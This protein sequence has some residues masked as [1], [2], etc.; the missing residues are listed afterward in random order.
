MIPI[1]GMKVGQYYTVFNYKPTRPQKNLK[2]QDRTIVAGIGKKLSPKCI[3]PGHRTEKVRKNYP[4]DALIIDNLETLFAKTVDKS[5]SNES[6]SVVERFTKPRAS[7]MFG[8]PVYLM[9][10][11]GPSIAVSGSHEDFSIV[12][13][14]YG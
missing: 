3:L 9:D 13:L 12:L 4:L 1:T 10:V 5:L 6:G 7:T 14:L 8:H 11:T 2:P